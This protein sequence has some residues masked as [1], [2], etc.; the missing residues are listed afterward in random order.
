MRSTEH[1]IKNEGNILLLIKS[2]SVIRL[3][4]ENFHWNKTCTKKRAFSKLK[5]EGQHTITGDTFLLKWKFKAF[6]SLLLWSDSEHSAIRVKVCKNGPSKI[7]GRQSLKNVK[8]LVYLSRPCPFRLSCTNFTWSHIIN[9]AKANFNAICV[10]VLCVTLFGRI[11]F[12]LFFLFIYLIKRGRI[13]LKLR[14]H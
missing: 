7:C 12:T 6:W 5:Q 1:V 3:S 9:C 13:C 4:F 10:P 2:P 8:R 11:F 14:D